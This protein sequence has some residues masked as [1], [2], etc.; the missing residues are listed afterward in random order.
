MRHKASALLVAVIALIALTG[1]R[2]TQAPVA[3]VTISGAILPA[4]YL[5]EEQE[6]E[7]FEGAPLNPPPDHPACAAVRD[8]FVKALETAAT[9]EDAYVHE[10]W[11][12]PDAAYTL[13]QTAFYYMPS[14]IKVYFNSFKKKSYAECI[15]A[16]SGEFDENPAVEVEVEVEKTKRKV[17]GADSSVVWLADRTYTPT[18]GPVSYGRS[19]FIQARLEDIVVVITYDHFS[20]DEE[21]LDEFED[22]YDALLKEYS[23]HLSQF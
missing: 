19:A 11:H 16:I 21:E 1:M 17:K 6:F 15:R 12:S 23:R 2:A 9:G 20:D 13:G 3:E 22:D 5:A 8:G 4:V 7:E 10:E 18:S 14:D